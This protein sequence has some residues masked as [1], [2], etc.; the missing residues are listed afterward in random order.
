ME[1]LSDAVY[2]E[3]SKKT[4]ARIL[5]QDAEIGKGAP[6]QCDRRPMDIRENPV[7]KTRAEGNSWLVVKRSIVPMSS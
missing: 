1:E 4:T 7:K 2:P 3:A 5:T 6:P